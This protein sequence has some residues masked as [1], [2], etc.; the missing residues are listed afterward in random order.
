VGIKPTG[1]SNNAA[2]LAQAQPQNG[3]GSALDLMGTRP[4]SRPGNRS[5][6]P[7]RNAKNQPPNPQARSPAAS[8]LP[9]L[10]KPAQVPGK[11]DIKVKSYVPG[12]RP[13]AAGTFPTE[14]TI[15]TNAGAATLTIKGTAKNLGNGG[16]STPTY[17]TTSAVASWNLFPQ[18]A[19]A[20][21]PRRDQVTVG[22]GTAG[23]RSSI[24]QAGLTVPVGRDGTF[25]AMTSAESPNNGKAAGVISTELGLGTKVG[26]TKLN[27]GVKLTD[28]QVQTNSR[29]LYSATANFPLQQKDTAVEVGVAYEN[30]RANPRADTYSA[31]ASFIKGSDQRFDVELKTGAE[32]GTSVQGRVKLFGF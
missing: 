20:T 11:V 18:K 4:A 25:S 26:T 8:N 27:V 17:P 19:G 22:V 10:K 12:A 21:T 6:G 9:S 2:S 24:V 15:T 1:N 32:I 13:G 3:R 31:T 14:R 5:N 30:N 7:A 29:T 28:A 23:G 16:D